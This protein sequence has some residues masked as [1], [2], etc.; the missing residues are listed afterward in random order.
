[1]K[2][3]QSII[4]VFMVIGLVVVSGCTGTEAENVEAQNETEVTET[5][6]YIIGTEPYFPPFEYA[7]ENNSN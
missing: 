5:V 3:I 2:K 6:T 4:L 1:M 7:D